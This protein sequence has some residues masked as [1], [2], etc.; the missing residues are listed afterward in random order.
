MTD[1]NGRVKKA[2][3]TEN[4]VRDST[5]TKF[6]TRKPRSVRTGVRAVFPS[7]LATGRGHGGLWGTG[8]ALYPHPAAGCPDVYRCKSGLKNYAIYYL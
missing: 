8:N 2:R 1:I 5:D 3:H 6:T 7:A 4:L